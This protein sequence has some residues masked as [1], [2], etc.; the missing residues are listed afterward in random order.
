[1]RKKLNSSLPSNS[2]VKFIHLTKPFMESIE[3]K[4]SI[5]SNLFNNSNESIINNT[6]NDLMDEVDDVNEENIYVDLISNASVNP[7]KCHIFRNPI[8]ITVPSPQ[9]FFCDIKDYSITSY[10]YVFFFDYLFTN[11]LT[12]KI[13]VRPCDTKGIAKLTQGQINQKVLE[14]PDNNAELIKETT[15]ITGKEITFRLKKTKNQNT[16]GNGKS[17]LSNLGI[18]INIVD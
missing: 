4:Y 13:W 18:D 14:M 9:K 10:E 8:Q 2:G 16:S 17:E 5:Q 1:M 7:L 3:D 12:K 11:R 15:K 6:N